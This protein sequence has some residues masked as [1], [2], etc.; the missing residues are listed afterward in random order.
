MDC[1]AIWSL[2]WRVWIDIVPSFT[3]FS[4]AEAPPLPAAAI[5][6]WR[7]GTGTGRAAILCH[8]GHHVTGSHM[9]ASSATLRGKFYSPDSTTNASMLFISYA[10]TDGAFCPNVSWGGGR[11]D[12]AP[13]CFVSSKTL[14]GDLCEVQHNSEKWGEENWSRAATNTKVT[15]GVVGKK[16]KL[17]CNFIVAIDHV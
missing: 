6:C 3:E 12:S 16:Y 2:F 1:V 4:A 15:L 8:D 10:N 11:R 7:R 17:S 13:W 9:V 14:R 5:L